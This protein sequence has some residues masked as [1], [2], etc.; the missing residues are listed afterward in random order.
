MMTRGI[1]A[2]VM[3]SYPPL[4]PLQ[5]RHT[6]TFFATLSL[7]TSDPTAGLVQ[8]SPVCVCVCVQGRIGAGE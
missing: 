6:L 4:S 3:L 5:T 8:N 2:G 1:P 7:R